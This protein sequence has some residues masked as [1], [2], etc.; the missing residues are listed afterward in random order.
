[1]WR[2]CEAAPDAWPSWTV[3]RIRTE[4]LRTTVS[5]SGKQDFAGRDKPSAHARSA[6][7]QRSPLLFIE[8]KGQISVQRSPRILLDI[9]AVKSSILEGKVCRIGG[10]VCLTTRSNR[11][12]SNQSLRCRETK[13]SGQRQR[14]LNGLAGSRTLLQRQNLAKPARQFGATRRGPGNLC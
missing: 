4:S 1:M 13:F 14:T 8:A 11:V 3:T 9:W 6:Y 7:K 5:V 12:S 10:C 2:Q